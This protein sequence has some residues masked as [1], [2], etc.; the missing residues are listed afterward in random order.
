M[1]AR[2]SRNGA[3]AAVLTVPVPCAFAANDAVR[4]IPNMFD[5]VSA[6]AESIR[7]LSFLVIGIAAGIFVVVSAVLFWCVWRYRQK[8]GDDSE[9]PQ[10]YGSN[11]IEW[12]WTIVPILI[13]LVLFLATAR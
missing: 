5:P 12:A 6:P 3:I 10:V 8:P 9:P 7:E 4:A 2:A 11:P 1:V 13:V